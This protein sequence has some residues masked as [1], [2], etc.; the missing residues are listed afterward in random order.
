V[1]CGGSRGWGNTPLSADEEWAISNVNRAR[2]LQAKAV[3][4]LFLQPPQSKTLTRWL[5][6]SEGRASVLD[7]GDPSLLFPAIL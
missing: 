2:W 5:R 6:V 4:A 7:C 3:S 1:E